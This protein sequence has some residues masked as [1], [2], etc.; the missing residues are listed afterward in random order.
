M[1]DQIKT[2][3]TNPVAKLV[4]NKS[5]RIRKLKSDSKTA[6]EKELSVVLKNRKSFTFPKLK[7]TDKEEI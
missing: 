5:V 7:E 1:K 2:K 6:K 3:I 4:T